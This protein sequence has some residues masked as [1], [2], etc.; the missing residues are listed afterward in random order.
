M[1]YLPEY[2]SPELLE[3]VKNKTM[4]TETSFTPGPWE[5]YKWNDGTGAVFVKPFTHVCQINHKPEREYWGNASLISAAPDLYEALKDALQMLQQ[6]KEYR[7]T[8]GLSMGEVFLDCTLEKA[9][10]A[11][12]KANP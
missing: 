5:V 11:L 4:K 3:G 2:D 6:F 12:S 9:S 7:Q 1:P 8:N 10:A